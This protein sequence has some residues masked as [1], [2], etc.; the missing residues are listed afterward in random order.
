MLIYI[1]IALMSI[2]F[3][4][5]FGGTL[6]RA[7]AKLLYWALNTIACFLIN[8]ADFC[9]RASRPRKGS[10]LVARILLQVVPLTD[11]A[12]NGTPA[13]FS[14]I[15]KRIAAIIVLWSLRYTLSLAGVANSLVCKTLLVIFRVVH[16]WRTAL[17][18]W[19]T[20]NCGP[21]DFA[22][23]HIVRLLTDLLN[24]TPPITSGY[25]A[26]ER[27][28]EYIDIF[29]LVLMEISTLVDTPIRSKQLVAS[30]KELIHRAQVELMMTQILAYKRDRDQTD[31]FTQLQ[32]EKTALEIQTVQLG[33]DNAALQE[34]VNQLQLENNEHA[35]LMTQM[36]DLAKTATATVDRLSSE[37]TKVKTANREMHVRLR[38]LEKA[39]IAVKAEL[40]KAGEEKEAGEAEGG[41]ALSGERSPDLP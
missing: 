37:H 22:G 21:H 1:L 6:S 26:C 2:V 15:L 30:A 29:S 7:I 31:R 8:T 3:G 17:L 13:T 35:L 9:E 38:D 39:D 10:I 4:G 12:P 41:V 40:S 33:T 14:T 36:H 32:L 18:P 27:L 25:D 5:T 23:I 28:T 16:S 19:V 34:A 20:S 11:R 24:T